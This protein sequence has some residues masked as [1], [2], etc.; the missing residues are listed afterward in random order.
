MPLFFYVSCAAPPCVSNFSGTG[1]LLQAWVIMEP[2]RASNCNVRGA[3]EKSRKDHFWAV[4][5]QVLGV[6]VRQE[7][8]V[9]PGYLS[10]VRFREV[11][12]VSL[13]RPGLPLRSAYPSLVWRSFLYGVGISTTA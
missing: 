2:C 12:L 7:S 1:V 5:P 8:A 10:G 11:L 3:S 9:C 6:R 4:C 13:P